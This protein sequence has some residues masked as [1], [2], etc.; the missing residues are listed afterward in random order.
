MRYAHTNIVAT[1]WRLL[2]DFYI[3][4]FG[5]TVKPPQRKQAGDWLARGTGVAD[6]A[7]EGVHLLL[8]G[9]GEHGP[10]LEIY[11]YRTIAP[12]P[13]GAAN[14]QGL[15]YLA[16]EVDDVA[17]TVARVLAK[18]GSLAGVVTERAI[19]GVG[20][21]TFVYARDPEG[22]L[23]ELQSWQRPDPAAR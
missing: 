5:C 15:G 3:E 9:H 2:A 1:D 8:P 23:I 14:R 10:T 21:L 4:T 18:V 17:E 6:A 11:T 16:F 20:L 7:L 13:P 12:Q 22:N 19:E